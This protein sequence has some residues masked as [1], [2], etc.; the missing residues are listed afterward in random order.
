LLDV[1]QRSAI[2]VADLTGA[3]LAGNAGFDALKEAIR[4]DE[5]LPPPYAAFLPGVPA[6]DIFPAATWARLLAA[7]SRSMSLD[8]AG[9]GVHIGGYPALRV[10]LAEHLRTSRGVICEPH[11]VI[12]TSSAR[13]GLTAMCRFL[14]G[15]GE[16]CLVEDPGYPIANR[17]IVGCGLQ[18]IP[19]PVD[20]GGMQ[21]TSHLPKARLAYVTPTHQLP[22]G[23]SLSAERGEALVAWAGRQRA[24]IIED[25]YDSEF[26]YAGRPVVALQ[27]LDPDGRIIHI[28]T[29]AKTMF[30]SLRV[31]FLVVPERLARDA[32]IAVHLSGQEPALHLQ[33]AL[34]D[35][36]VEGHYAALIKRARTVYRRRQRLLIGALNASLGGLLTIPDQAGGMNLLVRLPPEIPA[37]KVQEL[38]ARQELHARAVA[39]YALKAKPPNALH[40]GFAPLLDR[41]IA[42]A[43]ERLA[44]AIRAAQTGPVKSR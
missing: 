15:P 14:A 30:P 35:F 9:E 32:A 11:Q 10:A 3:G 23:V 18:A 29:F 33:A 44:R 20:D 5:G 27:H 6:F 21:I 25:D 43:A 16:K 39:Y 36:I 31:G 1:R 34:A 2:L 13:A 28:G 37:L 19:V 7:R 40:L 38:A 12:V 22:L 8:L 17:I 24:W 4:N 41:L 42:P 26:R